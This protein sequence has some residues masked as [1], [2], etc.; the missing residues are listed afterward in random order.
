MKVERHSIKDLH[1][2]TGGKRHKYRHVLLNTETQKHNDRLART[3]KGIVYQSRMEMLRAVHLDRG[4]V[5]WTR[6]IPFWLGTDAHK[7]VIDFYNF[8][9]HGCEEVKGF[10]TPKDRKHLEMFAKYGPCK[11]RVIRLVDGRW[12]TIEEISP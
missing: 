12:I 7:V 1:L 5:K 2:L 8:D 10:I 6:Q 4:G 3:Y 11:L 9:T